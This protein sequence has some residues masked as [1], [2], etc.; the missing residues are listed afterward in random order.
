MPI[1]RS[2]Y[3]QMTIYLFKHLPIHANDTKDY[4]AVLVHVFIPLGKLLYDN[5]MSRISRHTSLTHIHSGE[6]LN[7]LDTV[8]PGGGFGYY[9]DNF[10]FFEN[11]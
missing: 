10:P 11:L 2:S 7:Y 1:G 8:S 5:D 6:T 3:A 9:L 4:V